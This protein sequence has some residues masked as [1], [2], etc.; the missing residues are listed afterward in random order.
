MKPSWVRLKILLFTVIEVAFVPPMHLIEDQGDVI[1]T[2]GAASETKLRV[3]L[4]GIGIG[5]FLAGIVTGQ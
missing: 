5:E 1:R 2:S 4:V 3:P